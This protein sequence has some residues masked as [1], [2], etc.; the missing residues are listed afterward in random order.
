V[1]LTRII[2]KEADI[3]KDLCGLLREK[4]HRTTWDPFGIVSWTSPAT[5]GLSSTETPSPEL[6]SNLHPSLFIQPYN[7]SLVHQYGATSVR[8][9]GGG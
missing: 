9:S 4:H 8:E 6:Y 5:P 7:E 3:A 1:F 2:I